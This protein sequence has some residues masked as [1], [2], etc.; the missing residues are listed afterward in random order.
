[1]TARFGEA[2]L[3]VDLY[4]LPL[5]AGGHSV[6]LNGRV[7]EAIAA[8]VGRRDRRDLYH[9]A[10]VVRVPTAAYIIE[11]GPVWQDLPAAT[12]AWWLKEPS[13]RVPQAGS[14]S[15]ATRSGAGATGSFPTS[16]KRSRALSA[17]QKT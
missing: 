3:G 14:S 1:M 13:E 15:F 12:E 4:W 16:A 10:L 9:S 2:K 17:S 6:R 5:G 7:F 8:R 11:Q